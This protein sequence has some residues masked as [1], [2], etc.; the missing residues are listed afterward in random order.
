MYILQYSFEILHLIFK[1]KDKALFLF[2]TLFHI[3]ILTCK[4]KNQQ[5]NVLKLTQCTHCAVPSTPANAHQGKKTK[6]KRPLY[7]I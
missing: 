2:S 4:I 5:R 6:E 3:K 1:F 7:H